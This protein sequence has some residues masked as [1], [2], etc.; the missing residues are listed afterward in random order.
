MAPAPSNR[1]WFLFDPAFSVWSRGRVRVHLA[2]DGPAPDPE[3]PLLLAANHVGWWDGFL[4]RRLQRRLRPDSRYF[5]IMLESQLRRY[6]FLRQ[7]GG[8]GFDP[9]SHR[10]LRSLIARLRELRERSPG[11]VV[12]FFPQGRIVPAH[13]RPLDFAPGVRLVA[14]ALAPSAVVPVGITMTPSPASPA[15]DAWILAGAPLKDP[16]QWTAMRLEEATSRLLDRVQGHLGSH[17]ERALD[18]WPPSEVVP[19]PSPIV[20]IPAGV[21]PSSAS[22]SEHWTTA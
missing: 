4:L 2:V 6:P 9:G 22:S 16:A 12:L 10:S 14:E 19:S 5:T 7:L 20:P 21:V 11:S 17:E 15:M 18:H 13:R 3:G 1:G 8:L